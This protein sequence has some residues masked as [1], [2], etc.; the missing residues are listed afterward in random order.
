MSESQPIEL[1][2]T[3]SDEELVICLPP[4]LPP[5][6]REHSESI[7][8]IPETQQTP[9]PCPSPTPLRDFNSEPE[10]L[11][12]LEASFPQ[13]NR[14]NHSENSSQDGEEDTPNLFDEDEF[15]PHERVPNLV[16]EPIRLPPQS[17]VNIAR[18]KLSVI[19]KD[20]GFALVTS[21][22]NQEVQYMVMKCVCSGDYR[23]G[24]TSR[25]DQVRQRQPHTQRTDCPFK[26]KLS[27]ARQEDAL[28]DGFRPVLL[29][30]ICND[31]NHP[32]IKNLL[33]SHLRKS[34]RTPEINSVTRRR[35]TLSFP[36]KRSSFGHQFAIN[37]PGDTKLGGYEVR[38]ARTSSGTKFVRYEA[39][40]VGLNEVLR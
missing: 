12:P 28:A 39:R 30:T 31:H 38:K 36:I 18:E 25:Y 34:S 19:A 22:S 23:T 29:V 5:L 10:D 1:S 17:T 4:S 15:G 21:S 37:D 11:D 9:S 8:I 7:I 14:A 27:R 35:V 13:P 16:H 6:K 3:S 26:I 2:D 24:R 32:P 33:L 20:K 40:D